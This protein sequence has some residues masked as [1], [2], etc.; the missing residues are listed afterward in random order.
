MAWLLRAL[1][2]IKLLTMR[3]SLRRDSKARGGEYS[4]V[5]DRQGWWEC[6]TIVRNNRGRP[7]GMVGV[8]NDCQEQSWPTA[9]HGGRMQRRPNDELIL[10]GVLRNESQL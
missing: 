5:F 7:P 2:N 4:A 8:P 6:R 3:M 9:I 10:T 1:V